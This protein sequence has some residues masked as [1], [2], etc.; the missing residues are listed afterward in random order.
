MGCNCKKEK[1]EGVKPNMKV[2]AERRMTI[3]KLNRCGQYRK[4]FSMCKDCGC[5]LKLKTLIH[6]QKC[7]QGH[8]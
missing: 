8:W 5:F 2:I 3:C 1:Q 7:P 6:N 4:L